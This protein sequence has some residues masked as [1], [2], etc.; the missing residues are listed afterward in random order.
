VD[1]VV[2]AP[3]RQVVAVME[4]QEEEAAGCRRRT[5]RRRPRQR[6]EIWMRLRLTP[7]H[8]DH[9]MGSMSISTA[10]GTQQRGS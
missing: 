7:W 2:K 5:G 8:G 6:R 1:Q 10:A 9:S 4:Y 3:S